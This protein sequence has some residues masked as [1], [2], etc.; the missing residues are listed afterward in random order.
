MKKSFKRSLAAFL[1][2]LMLVTSFPIMA[3]ATTES[4]VK[5]SPGT[6]NGQPFI[7]NQPSEIYRIP[8][9][10]SLDDGTIV[11]AADARW[12][13]GMDGGG[14]DTIVARSTDGGNTWSNQFVNYY[15]DNGNKFNK[16]STSVCDTELVTDGTNIWML[17]VF[18]PAGYAINAASADHQLSGKTG[19]AFVDINGT[20]RLK[21]SND[22]GSTYN[23]YL[24]DFDKDG[25]AGR[26][27]IYSTTGAA[28]AYSVDHDYY[29]YS[30]GTKLSAQNLFYSDSTFQ[31]AKVNFLLLR[32]S[33]D[34]GQTWS[35]F[36]PINVK[37]PDESFCGVG[38]GR[39]VYDKAHN[40]ILLSV[41]NWSGNSSSQ[42]TSIIFSDDGGKTWSR[43]A[44][45]PDLAGFA[46]A[47]HWSSESALVQMDDNTIRCF[48]RNGWCKINYA[49]AVLQSDGSYKWSAVKDIQFQINGDPGTFGTSNT[50]CQLS[51]IKYSKKLQY[52]GHY[53]TAVLL[54][55]PQAQ[56]ANGVVY[57]MLFDENNNIV[58]SNEGSEKAIAYSLNS[59][60]FAYSCLTELPDG[61]IADL[62][63]INDAKNITFT[64]LPEI[65]KL[66][67]LR[68]PNEPKTYNYTLPTGSTQTYI[69][70]GNDTITDN[71]SAV[72]EYKQRKSVNA[73]MGN[74]TAFDGESI[75]LS[76]AL[77]DFTMNKDG[78]WVIGS[79]GVYLT[80]V[81]PQLPSS[82]KKESVWIQP[83]NGYFRFIDGDGEALAFWRSGDKILQYDQSTAHGGPGANPDK[84]VAA[85]R[86]REMCLFEVYRP[87]TPDE[88]TGT[89]TIPGFIRVTDY[90]ELKNGGQYIIG[91]EVNGS[92]YFLYPSTSTSNTFSHSVKMNP[93]LV[94]DGYYVTV[95]PYKAGNLT[96]HLGEDTYNFDFVDYSNEILGVVDYDPVI[97]THGT[98]SATAD[99][100]FTHVGNRIAD[101]T[102]MGEKE[103]CFRFKETDYNEDGKI[104]ASDDLSTK[105][106]IIS[107]S[108][109]P[110]S[111]NVT[112]LN[113]T[114]DSNTKEYKLTGNLDMANTGEYIDYTK[115]EYATIKTTLEE[116]DTNE[117]YTQTD[118]LYVTSN[119]VPAHIVSGMNYNYTDTFKEK[120]QPFCTYILAPGSIGNTITLSGSNF[121]GTNAKHIF[122]WTRNPG[123]FGNENFTYQ[124]AIEQIRQVDS[125]E[126][127]IKGAGITENYTVHKYASPNS[128]YENKIL[129]EDQIFNQNMIMGYYYYDKSSPKNEGVTNITNNGNSFSIE[130][131]RKFVDINFGA[132][133]WNNV[134]ITVGGTYS[135]NR[136][137]F[138]AQLGG[139][140]SL[141]AKL[142]GSNNSDTITSKSYDQVFGAAGTYNTRIGGSALN[143]NQIAALEKTATA[144]CT[145]NVTPNT[146]G[147]L[148]GVL[149]YQE[150]REDI[151]KNIWNDIVF[152]FEVKYCDK[153]V[154]RTAYNNSIK[155]VLKSTDYTSSTWAAYMNKALVYQE[156]LN[157]YIIQ[158]KEAYNA[159]NPSNNLDTVY[160]AE[161]IPNSYNNIQKSA[162][163]GELVDQINEKREILAQGIEI[164]NK[165]NYTPSSFRNLEAACDDN[166]KFYDD[167]GIN[168]TWITL[169][170]TYSPDEIRAE[171]PG[172]EIG[173]YNTTKTQVQ[174]E[175]ESRTEA[176]KNNTLKIA[177]DDSAYLAAKDKYNVIDKTAYNDSGAAINT[178]FTTNDPEIYEDFNGKTY[179][180]KAVDEQGFIDAAIT[181]ALTEMN[182]GEN[183]S[184]SNLKTYN[185]KITVNGSIVLDNNYKYGEVINYD[186]GQY[187]G[188]DSQPVECYSASI[189][190]GHV[191]TTTVNLEDYASL[192]YVVPILI[193]ND[194]EISLTVP[195]ISRANENQVTVTDYYGTILGV[196]TGTE[197]T[198]SG[199]TVTVGDQTITA[200]N[201]PRYEFTGW[202]V[203][204]GTY[205]IEESMV[206]VQRGKLIELGSVFN[207]EGG[208]VN[209]KATFN[210]NYLNIKLNLNSDNAKYWTRT[211]VDDAGNVLVPEKLVSYEKDFVN[212]SSLQN[213]NYKAY[214]DINDLPS[215]IKNKVQASEPAV[216]GIGYFVN[217]KFTLSV[218]YSAP[219]NVK[220]LDAG[221]I[222]SSVSGDNLVKGGADA[223]IYASPRIAHW[224]TDPAMASN[225]GTFTM[226]TS[227]N[228]ENGA[229]MRAYV[230]YSLKY[231]NYELPYVAYSD[232]VYKCTK[233]A[234]GTYTVTPMN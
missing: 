113:Y 97:Y 185:V 133:N 42:R 26:A 187:L 104:D 82:V 207:A 30:N 44:D 73:N 221:I 61:S 180:D 111:G 167:A 200:K 17:T 36:T 139:D 147:S 196:L 188:S 114:Y 141:I 48:V 59:S 212:F 189:S 86:D 219:E 109:V 143:D 204:D 184:A 56:R 161:N 11:A 159:L 19:T 116:I 191:T 205:P 63:E 34:G 21:L 14:N 177:A 199:D 214:T 102:Y 1:A 70:K 157:N 4:G 35:D 209:G 135:G 171:T 77:Y 118:R 10:V 105:F 54:S 178:V 103:T 170:G 195:N 15:P 197:V 28:T 74:S 138:D 225:S 226:S 131:Q 110:D 168:G 230:S 175:I 228:L 164:S 90:D 124:N 217:G 215:Y 32:K 27:T 47:S 25:A 203:K 112:T 3:F 120:Y 146:A 79:M 193:Q 99:M 91:C 149:R 169:E 172:W 194:I 87:A 130:L 211:V 223:T 38:P 37:N 231:D 156:Y 51:A 93:T 106:R 75:P 179:V 233:Q 29:L 39:G 88:N 117:I 92:H 12:D 41:Y 136:S 144:D 176:L 33:T 174:N 60:S 69:A 5:P 134:V 108:A 218:D 153:S 190:N 45:F 40:R 101:G 7:A 16:S 182:V 13:G 206:I 85:D 115:G 89:N 162:Q 50:G 227:K 22:N 208:T 96:L 100:D 158:T 80:V 20:A 154:E 43:T 173:P 53:Y 23:Y 201:S 58:N 166:Q 67:G 83:D 213:V 129:S 137:N 94:N 98:D 192:N 119:P 95:K 210:T 160:E 234:D 49:D 55:T 66:T 229:Y 46:S 68:V 224:S 65:T 71:G 76:D 64:K 155:N 72:V 8:A 57:T 132:D 216:S 183:S 186:F 198:V 148:V 222:F 163:F 165:V 128:P 123:A 81:E 107:V 122:T 181:D 125:N 232:A 220:V 140:R 6:T 2:I 150:G 78:S 142:R 24:G 202:S 152:P 126:S 31:T 84:G 52:N 9:M 62:Y 121:A 151:D 127:Q 18:F 145:I